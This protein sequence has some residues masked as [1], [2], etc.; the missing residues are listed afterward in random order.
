MTVFWYRGNEE[1]SRSYEV[2][3]PNYCSLILIKQVLAS[4]QS[5]TSAAFVAQNYFQLLS[6]I[7]FSMKAVIQI[8]AEPL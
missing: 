8:L 1:L 6:A 5:R 2:K 7:L 4:F 3:I